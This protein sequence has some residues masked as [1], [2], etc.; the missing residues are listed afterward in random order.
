M[1]AELYA[2]LQR[3]YGDQY[4]DQYPLVADAEGGTNYEL[5]RK[6]FYYYDCGNEV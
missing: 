1:E 2:L 5:C 3:Q 4:G 6:G